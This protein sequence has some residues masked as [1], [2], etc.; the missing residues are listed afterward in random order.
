MSEKT[1]K[2]LHDIIMLI[3]WNETHEKYHHTCFR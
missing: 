1:F 3:E 2:Y